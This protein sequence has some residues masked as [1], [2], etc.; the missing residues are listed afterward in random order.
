MG[1]SPTQPTLSNHYL[2]LI[3]TGFVAIF[4][5]SPLRTN[6]PGNAQKRITSGK[7]LAS[8]Y[9]RSCASFPVKIEID[10]V[11]GV[12][13]ERSRAFSLATGWVH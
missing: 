12:S 10:L 2:S 6:M 5:K 1:S 13:L 7:Y 8:D 4:A 11:L 3:N 9:S